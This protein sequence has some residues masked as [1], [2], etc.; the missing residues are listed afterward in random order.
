MCIRDSVVGEEGFAMEIEYKIT[1]EDQLIIKQARPWASFWSELELPYEPLPPL[2]IKYF[3]NPVD[4]YLNIQCNCD[5]AEINIFNLLGQPIFSQI[6]DSES[7]NTSTIQIP[8]N[9]LSQ[10]VYVISGF[11]A[12]NI[13]FSAKFFKR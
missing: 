8:T 11:G 7:T 5:L 13:Y 2:E 4:D 1:A 9:H 12:N 10:G 3:P 6:I